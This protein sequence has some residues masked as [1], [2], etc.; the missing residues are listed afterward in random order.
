MLA[1]LHTLFCVLDFGHP[2]TITNCYLSPSL[3]PSPSLCLTVISFCNG[4]THT[5]HG[6]FSLHKKFTSVELAVT[7][8]GRTYHKPPR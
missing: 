3:S 8:N 7:K 2:Y 4:R 6:V 5:V 1:K